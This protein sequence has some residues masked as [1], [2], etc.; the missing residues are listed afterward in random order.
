[1]MAQDQIRQ[2]CHKDGRK[3]GWIAEQI[4]VAKSSLSR[5]MTGRIVPSQVYRHRLADIT[6]IENLRLKEEWM[7]K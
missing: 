1:M 4:P 3:L 2:W 5:W 6:E 7:A